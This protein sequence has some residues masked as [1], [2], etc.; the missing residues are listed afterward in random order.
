MN[1]TYATTG[2]N[3]FAG[4]QTVNSNLVVTGS[5]TAQTLVVQTITSSVDFVTGS[6][7]FGSISENTH[8]FTGSMSVSGSGTFTSALSGTSATFS[9]N[10]N[11][12]AG[13]VRNINFYDSSNTNIN[14]QIQY[15]QISSNSGQL[16]FGTNNAGTF[17]T[18]FTIASTGAATFSNNIAVGGVI[19]L[20][21]SIHTSAQINFKNVGAEFELMKFPA[22]NN[23]LTLFGATDKIYWKTDKGSIGTVLSMNTDGN[24]GIGTTAPTSKLFVLGNGSYNSSI[25]ETLTSDATI[26][27]SEMTNDAYNSILQLV[28]VRQSLSTGQGSNG[29]LGFSTI[30]DSNGQGI[31][32]AGR[33]AIVNETG[34]AR[35]S[36][37]ALGFW[38]NSTGTNTGAATERMRVSSAGIVTKPYHPVFHV[39]KGNGNVAGATTVVWN[40]IFTNVGS[41]YNDSNGRFTAPVAGVY[42]FAFSVMSDGDVGMDMQL[43]KNGV[44]YQG[45]VPLQSAIGST[46]NQLTG[47]CTITLAASDYV[48]VYNSTGTMYATSDSGRH[49][50]FCGF[51]VG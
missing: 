27:S 44:V 6:T 49:T 1:G 11:L 2:S 47:V 5:I 8:Q 25:S 15:D 46:Y 18:R 33:I 24:V 39:G 22:S 7:R 50:M 45:C 43:Q 26:F 48:S 41:Y 4:I 10:L 14:A 17:A 12:Q 38:T 36:L 34:T 31:R 19:T 28:S 40:V 51:L 9:G 35:N 37:T 42:Y 23:T 16:F 29:F 32:D 20:P 30:D 21:G 13:A 3:T